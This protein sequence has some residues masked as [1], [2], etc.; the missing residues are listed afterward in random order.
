[1][2]GYSALSEDEHTVAQRR[3][4][5]GVRRTDRDSCPRPGRAQNLEMEIGFRSDIHTLCGFVE[6]QDAGRT[7]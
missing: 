1:V 2:L 7:T 3:Q 6:K 4:F 5:V